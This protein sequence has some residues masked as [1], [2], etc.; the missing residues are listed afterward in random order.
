MK[1]AMGPFYPY[2]T[3]GEDLEVTVSKPDENGNIYAHFEEPDEKIGF[4]TLDIAIFNLNTVNN[5]GFDKKEIEKAIDFVNKNANIM[6]H[7]SLEERRNA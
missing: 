4:K 6:T 7:I 1:Q 5:I 3:I 2:C